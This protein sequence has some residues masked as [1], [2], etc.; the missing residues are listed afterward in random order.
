MN[1]REIPERL[2]PSALLLF[3][4]MCLQ[5]MPL[6]PGAAPTDWHS[7]RPA[8]GHGVLPAVMGG[9]G[10]PAADM[11]WLRANRAWERRDIVATDALLR[12]VVALEPEQDYFRINAAR[13]IAFDFPGW[14]LPAG[15][16]HEIQRR[17]RT[18]CAERA[19]QLLVAQPRPTPAVVIERARLTHQLLGERSDAA[20]LYQEASRLPGAPYFAGRLAVELLVQ[21]GRIEEARTW[22]RQWVAELPADEP[23]AERARMEARLAELERV[24]R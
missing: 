20:A 23:T 17:T 7:L 22:L 19:L 10:A 6:G 1:A 11:L 24:R 2:G 15:A 12:A 5:A 21:D 8:A 4:A 9:W 13:I 16:P 3:G 14:E 18:D